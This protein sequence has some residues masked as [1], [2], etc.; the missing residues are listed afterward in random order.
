MGKI[1]TL[2]H[3]PHPTVTSEAIII[4]E[5][6]PIGI[7]RII[8]VIV[9]VLAEVEVE[10][11]VEAEA[12]QGVIR[13]IG[14]ILAGVIVIRFKNEAISVDHLDDLKKLIGDV[15]IVTI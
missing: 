7:I 10:V 5:V 3:V 1:T 13:G 15:K 8:T 9:L 11:E 4:T 12:I 2:D 14:R 6:I